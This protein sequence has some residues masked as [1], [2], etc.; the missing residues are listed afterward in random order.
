MMKRKCP[1]LPWEKGVWALGRARPPKGRENRDVYRY[2]S[3]FHCNIN[4]PEIQGGETCG[5]MVLKREGADGNGRGAG[6]D[7][8]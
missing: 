5:F 6:G 1:H 7:K 8:S 2:G 4:C 3:L